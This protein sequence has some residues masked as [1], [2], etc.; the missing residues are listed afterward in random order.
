MSNFLICWTQSILE[1]LH[2]IFF[3]NFSF[4]GVIWGPW[5]WWSW[6]KN[7]FEKLK[8]FLDFQSFDSPKLKFGPFWRWPCTFFCPKN[9][10]KKVFKLL[11]YAPWYKIGTKRHCTKV[12]NL[13]FSWNK[14]LE[15]HLLSHENNVFFCTNGH[16]SAIQKLFWKK[17][18]GQKKVH[19]YLQNDLNFN[20]NLKKV[21]LEKLFFQFI[22]FIFFS[23]L[24]HF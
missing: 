8:F 4:W 3:G 24:P 11:K 5:K 16:T 22:F 6:K 7:I 12:W 23:G 19:G 21:D 2:R 1:M 20:F 10:F 17:N 15:N 14:H 9:Y 18:C 13:V